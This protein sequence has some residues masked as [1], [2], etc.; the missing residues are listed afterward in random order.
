VRRWQED[1]TIPVA[2]GRKKQE[3]GD[4]R[5]GGGD[6]AEETKDGQ[7]SAAPSLSLPLRETQGKIF[8]A[9]RPASKSF[10]LSIPDTLLSGRIE[11]P[12]GKRQGK[13]KPVGSP[14]GVGRSLPLR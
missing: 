5:A 9:V 2:G 10:F 1:A 6:G 7:G 11:G 4:S 8:F 13:P 3:A 12:A 14:F